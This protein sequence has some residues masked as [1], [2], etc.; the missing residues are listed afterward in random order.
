[1]S[2]I[3]EQYVKATAT[4]VSEGADLEKTIGGMREVMARRGHL[5]LLPAVLK[6]LTTLL[7][8]RARDSAPRLTL[9]READAKLYTELAQGAQIVIDE[10]I[11][12]GY[13]YK[14][15]NKKTDGSYRT[16]LLNWYKAS[17]NG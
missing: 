8:R 17:I 3:K 5:R 13:I 11:I 16:K 1:M 10:N 7:E 4:L 14:N 12:G 15:G 9:A 6:S 2:Q